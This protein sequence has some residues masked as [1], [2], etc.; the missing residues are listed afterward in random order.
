MAAARRTCHRAAG[1]IGIGAGKECHAARQG[2]RRVL[3]VPVNCCSKGGSGP[4]NDRAQGRR[5]P[6]TDRMAGHPDV[7]IRCGRARA[8]VPGTLR[9]SVAD[10]QT[11][12]GAKRGG[13]GNT[14]TQG[15]HGTV[16]VPKRNHYRH[17]R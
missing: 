10:R 2:L 14:G 5:L 11:P 9:R 16:P 6:G 17:A 15:C 4:L 12:A 1:G 13:C 3:P 8:L 7:R